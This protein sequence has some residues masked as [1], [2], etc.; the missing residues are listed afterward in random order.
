MY[1][2]KKSSVAL[3]ILLPFSFAAW[4]EINPEAID[5]P[6]SADQEPLN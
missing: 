1:L 6:G 5:L 3:Y 2:D 4:H